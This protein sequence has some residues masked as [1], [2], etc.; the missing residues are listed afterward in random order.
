MP[1]QWHR[2]HD[3]CVR[4]LIISRRIRSRIQKRFSPWIRGPWGIVWWKNRRSKISWHYPFPRKHREALTSTDCW[5]EIVAGLSIR[6]VENIVSPRTK[7]LP[8]NSEN[9]HTRQVIIALLNNIFKLILT[10]FLI[11]RIIFNMLIVKYCTVNVNFKIVTCF[12]KRLF[13]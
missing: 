1:C 5:W 8:R 13:L 11:I 9:C 12:C 3:F 7:I 2:M 4:K 6:I 10:I